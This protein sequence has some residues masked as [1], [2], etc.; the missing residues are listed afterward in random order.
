[1][2]DPG[3]PTDPDVGREPDPDRPGWASPT[4]PPSQPPPTPPPAAPTPPPPPPP[5]PP[6]EPGPTQPGAPAPGAAPAWG[7]PAPG[8]GAAP[9]G[10]AVPP[11]A[12][13]GGWT[14]P[15]AAPRKRRLT[16]VWILIPV[17]LVFV[18]STVVVIVFAVR[19]LTGPIQ[20]TNDY[21]ADLRDG[22]YVAAYS[23]L[24]S[25]VRGDLTQADF[26]DL[27]RSDART[28]GRVT[29]FDF[30]S[31]EIH[32]HTAVTTG[33]VDRGGSQYDSHVGLRKEG[34]DWK[35]CSVHER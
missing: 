20:T 14:Q 32:N 7:T 16:W 6:P 23:E 3:N 5:A 18:V 26:V 33:T 1:M 30:H 17:L 24:C 25:G 10:G 15:G 4:P 12:A 8:W 31:F 28:K 21:Y 9:P 29:S 27:Q 2:G 13:G 19:L 11:T 22:Q 35:V 34:G